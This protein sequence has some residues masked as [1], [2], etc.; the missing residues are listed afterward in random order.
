MMYRSIDEYLIVNADY[1]ANI[2]RINSRF[3]IAESALLGGGFGLPRLFQL[4][5]GT[6]YSAGMIDACFPLAASLRNIIRSRGWIIRDTPRTS[7]ALRY[8]TE[9][10]A[11]GVSVNN[12]PYRKGLAQAIQACRTALEIIS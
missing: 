1:H 6:V 11:V 5:N 9:T 12:R 2:T 3:F 7:R 4:H 10:K 8:I